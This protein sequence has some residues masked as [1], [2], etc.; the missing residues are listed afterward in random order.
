MGKQNICGF[1]C[2]FSSLHL[3]TGLFSDKQQTVMK[4]EIGDPVHK[5]LLARQPHN[6]WLSD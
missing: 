4:Y 1:V 3:E 6:L 5:P 2:C